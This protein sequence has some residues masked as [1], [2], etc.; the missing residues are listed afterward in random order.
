MNIIRVRLPEGTKRFKPFTV[1]DYRDFLLIRNDLV[2]NKAEEQE[3]VDELLEELYPNFTPAERFY[4]FVKVF[5]SSI[6]KSKMPIVFTCPTCGQ[7]HKMI[8]DLAL[9]NMETPTVTIDNL[10]LTFN[11]PDVITDDYQKLFTDTIST[12]SDGE[13]T[14]K[15]SDLG[16]EEKNAVIDMVTFDVFEQIVKKLHPVYISRKFKC[17]DT[18]E[19]VYKDILSVFKLLLNPDEIFLFYRINRV[20]TRSEYS[21]QDIMQM[22]PVERQIALSLIEKENNPK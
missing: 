2:T 1:A 7:E 19:M 14:Y 22:L 13:N 4:I 16:I 17:C 6:G 11:Y 15:W 5:T 8:L 18:H 3:I 10:T 20:L 12:V 21:L 9:P